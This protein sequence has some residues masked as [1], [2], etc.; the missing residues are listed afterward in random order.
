MFDRFEAAA[1]LVV[2]SKMCSLCSEP[3]ALSFA[4][5]P[6]IFCRHVFWV[7]LGCSAK[8]GPSCLRFQEM[9]AILNRKNHI[10]HFSPN[11]FWLVQQ[12]LVGTLL[13]VRGTLSANLTLNNLDLKKSRPFL[14]SEIALLHL[15]PNLFW[16]FQQ[17]LVGTLLQARGTLSANLT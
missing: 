4:E 1:A 12:N 13:G 8:S 17:N 16:L 5:I 6:I 9:A 2:G 11:L 3:S 14:G 7:D 15:S 10:F